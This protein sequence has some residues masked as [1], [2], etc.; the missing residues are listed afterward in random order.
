M[1][2]YFGGWAYLQ[3]R[4]VIIVDQRGEGVSQPYLADPRLGCPELGD[5]DIETFFNPP[6][7][8]ANYGPRFDQAIRDCRARLVA[9]GVDLRGYN[10][11]EIAGDLEALRK[12]LGVT[13]WNLW[14][15]SADGVQGLTYMRLYPGGIRSAVLD[16]P[17][18][19]AMSIAPD[20][21]RGKLDNLE[22]AFTGCASTPVCAKKYPNLRSVFYNVVADLNAHP[23][24]ITVHM[25]GF[26]GTLHADGAGF[27]Q[28]MINGTD[29]ENIMYILNFI[30]RAGHGELE[31]AYN[32]D[33]SG[34]PFFSHDEYEAS[35]RT[36]STV[37]HDLVGFISPAEYQQLAAD[38]PGMA[39]YILDPYFD[40]PVGK[41]ACAI[42]N[43]G[44]A[45]AA[46]HKPVTSTIPTMITAG[47]FD[48][49]VP[50]YIIRQIPAT[51]KNGYLFEFPAT[52]HLPL[53]GYQP[54]SQC[55]RSIAAQF[56]DAPTS[57]PNSSCIASLPQ[58]DYKP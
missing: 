33:F 57:R 7:I 42:W 27:M 16:S 29:A 55:A 25:T 31:Q 47:E 30:W 37:C 48:T 3:D 43:N 17:Q 18:N 15:A 49:G 56:L 36:L 41:A 10:A 19:S 52:S 51:L 22:R 32:G 39:S 9:S 44:L 26:T 54:S 20:Y 40:H 11:A 4:D 6:F 21:F 1:F 34:R 35:G 23:R 46:Q 53:A 2:Y 13:K 5:A 28:D 14:V 12:A 38:I 24:D 58:L 50:R 8:G 45:E